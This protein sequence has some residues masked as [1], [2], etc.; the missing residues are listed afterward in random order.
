MTFSSPLWAKNTSATATAR[1][2]SSEGM[3]PAACPL[4]GTAGKALDVM[5]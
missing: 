4:A 3:G 2:P 1:M 5:A